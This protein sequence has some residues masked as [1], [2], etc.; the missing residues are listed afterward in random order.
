[1]SRIDDLLSKMTLDE[2]IS[3]LAGADLWHSVAVPRLGIP[4]FKTTD[5]PNGARGAWGSMASPSVATP[6]GIAL[7]ATWNPELVEK[8]GNVL[9]DELEAK[10]AHILL[11]PTVNIHRTPIAGR[12]FECYSEDP[13]HSGMM[14]SAYIKGIQDK[15][16]GACIKHFV[17]NDQEYER[18]SMSSEMDERTLREI[19]LEPFR[20]AIRNSNPWAVM[21]SYNRVNGTYACEYDHTLLEILKG[22]WGYEGIV[23]SDWFGTYGE[24]AP[25]GGLDLEMPGPAR[26]MANTVVKKVLASGAL[27]EEMLDDKIRRLL[28]V[29][30][31]AGLF[32]KPEQQPE[33]AE[34]KPQHR[35][36]MREAARE[37]IVLLKNDD[38][39]PFKKVKSIAVIG[40]YAN[41]PQILGGGSS[42]VTPH[43]V[44]TPFE[45]IKNRAGKKIKV[46]TALGCF[47]YKN[48]PAPAPETLSTEDGRNGLSLSLF[49]GIEFKGAPVYS[50]ITTH[51]QHDWFHY[52]VPNANQESFSMLLEGLFTPKESGVHMLSLSGVGWCKLYLDDQ[53]VI[54]HSHDSDMGKQ[55]TAEVEL[56][57]GKSYHIKVEYYWK[58]NPRS[59]SVALGH[60]PPQPLDPITEAVKLAKKS[61]V[62]V[63][64]ASL[65]GE[66]ETEGADRVDMKL[67]GLQNELIERVAKANKHTIVVV[68]V[69]S[70]VEMPWIDK[71]PAVVQLWYDSQEQGNALA[72]VLFGDINPSGKLPTTFPVHLEDNPTYIN[73]PGENGKVRYGEGIFVGYR[74]YDKK[75]VAPL[76]PFGHGLSYTKFKYSNL[77]LNAKSI[78]PS[79]T[80]KVKVDVTNTGK[81]AGQEIV[82]LYVRDV[83]STFARPEKELK[84]FVKVELKPKQAKT[85]MFTLDREAFW[86]FDT[87][88]NAWNTEPG[89]FEVWVGASSRDIRE[90]RTVILEPEP[91]T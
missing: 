50:E 47:V 75:G 2:K 63:L 23:M 22:E 29:S 70:A 53:F 87:L 30:E 26:W 68:N 13:Y 60:Q 69:G 28:L 32:E 61:D 20:I 84:G 14:A 56:E 85:V 81:I 62:V 46:E 42:S 78:K 1:M 6:V 83:K 66:W 89:E 34:D 19:Y 39:L 21:S 43:Y 67:P 44:V 49:N 4:Q 18:C 74:Y 3:M 80:L 58:G 82:Q 40:P 59:R 45:G 16:R 15:G 7:G 64:V 57:G 73:Y 38:A 33:R 91:R 35:K 48:L 10:G 77:R 51:V 88:K 90:K 5:G 24:G 41:A 52:S 31:K 25:A 9:A 72:D 79:E 86:Y 54:D 12:N 76:F 11:A 36:I 27:T 71:V 65:N 17:A 37:A 8:V 55:I